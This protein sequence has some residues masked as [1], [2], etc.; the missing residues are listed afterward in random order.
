MPILWEYVLSNYAQAR[1][2][3]YIVIICEDDT[4]NNLTVNASRYFPARAG[5]YGVV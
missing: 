5:F 3:M 2:H 4:T 1:T